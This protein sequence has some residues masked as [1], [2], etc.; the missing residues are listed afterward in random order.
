M[1]HDERAKRRTTFP[2]A[3]NDSGA[4]DEAA[5]QELFKGKGECKLEPGNSNWNTCHKELHKTLE[6]AGSLG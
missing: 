2:Q 6:K 3:D 4:S 1:P 5:K